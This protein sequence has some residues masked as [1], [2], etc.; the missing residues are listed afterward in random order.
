V[1][2]CGAPDKIDWEAAR[3]EWLLRNN[4]RRVRYTYG[5]L[6]TAY[7]VS[8]RRVKQRASKEKWEM[9][10][11]MRRRGIDP[12]AGL[13][14]SAVAELI[15]PEYVVFNELEVRIRQ[16]SF[17]RAASALG[18]ERLKIAGVEELT[19][20]QAIELLRLGLQEERKA[21][22]IPD[23]FRVQKR[24]EDEYTDEDMRQLAGEMIHLMRQS[25]GVYAESN[26]PADVVGGADSGVPAVATLPA[27]ASEAGPVATRSPRRARR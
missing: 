4:D 22:G 1:G 26:S 9:L 8:E 25:D 7:G 15:L 16:A 19:I 18:I 24:S 27:A 5:Q 2:R 17:A 20:N 6:A 23:E 14:G 11:E 21:L 10:L 12:Q 3:E 13:P